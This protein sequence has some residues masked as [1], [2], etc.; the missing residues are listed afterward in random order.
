MTD[1]CVSRIVLW[2]DS[3]SQLQAGYIRSLANRYD[4]DLVCAN[5]LSQARLSLGW[6]EADFGKARLIIRPGENEIRELVHTRLPHSVHVISSPHRVATSRRAYSMLVSTGAIVGLLAEGRDWRGIKGALRRLESFVYERRIGKR[7]D[8]VLAMGHTSLIWHGMCGIPEEKI[9]PFGYFPVI[10]SDGCLPENDALHAGQEE[11]GASCFKLISVGQLIARKRVHLLFKALAMIKALAWRL[12]LIGGG[13]E[14]SKLERMAK[15]LGLSDRVAFAGVI[16]NSLVPR[17]M[18]KADL[19]VL[20]SVWDGWGAVINEALGAGVPAV[21]S[22][23][24]GAQVLLGGERGETFPCGS[25]SG[26]ANVLRSRILHGRPSAEVRRRIRTWSRCISGDA[27]SNYLSG[28]I[29]YLSA[30]RQGTSVPRPI[31]PW[32]AEQDSRL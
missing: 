1:I 7:L 2:Q 15:D 10:R 28:I 21:C 27:A 6:E 20:P 3:P 5:R 8:F 23:F 11:N 30:K 18:G 31:A 17:E 14:R 22:D 25:V 4:L 19:L 12:T 9:F 26:L 13:P 29:F 16:K 24:C 32:L